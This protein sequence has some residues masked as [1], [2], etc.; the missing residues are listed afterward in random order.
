MNSYRVIKHLVEDDIG[1]SSKAI[2]NHFIDSTHNQNFKPPYDCGDLK[3]C[4]NAVNSLDL[5]NVNHM[6]SVSKQWKNISK[7]WDALVR[8]FNVDRN[9]CYSLLQE[10]IK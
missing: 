5:N 2:I 6:E 10:C 1:L 4:I 9:E 7:N 8:T 3:R